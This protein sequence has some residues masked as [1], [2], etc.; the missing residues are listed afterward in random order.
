MRKVLTLT[1]LAVI[2]VATLGYPG[3][4]ATGD[5]NE[6]R[7]KLVADEPYACG[8]HFLARV[9]EGPTGA[10]EG[11]HPANRKLKRLLKKDADY[12]PGPRHGWIR[13]F[14]SDWAA[15][16]VAENDSGRSWAYIGLKKRNGKWRWSYS[17]DT[18]RPLAWARKAGGGTLSLRAAHPPTSDSTEL[19]L[20][21][22]EQACHGTRVPKKEDVHPK[23]IYGEENVVV[24]VRIEFVKGAT[25]CPGTPPFRYT[26]KLDEPLGDR[27][28]VDAGEYP[29]DVLQKSA[30]LTKALADPS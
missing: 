19:R 11:D 28:L 20:H 17:G 10:E 23:V 9:L 30:D 18:C 2:S 24:I 1:V 26:V 3:A 8:K 15:E 25:T 21:V 16:F 29:P 7:R 5:Q 4:G 22:H 14:L 27:D 13:V 6:S 12:V